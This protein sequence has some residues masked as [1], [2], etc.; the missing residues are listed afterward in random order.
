VI[1]RD[2]YLLGALRS[3]FHGLI[4][5]YTRSARSLELSLRPE[6]AA[7]DTLLSKQNEEQRSSKCRP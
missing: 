7:A 6:H 2:G 4:R 5:S 3:R 1:A